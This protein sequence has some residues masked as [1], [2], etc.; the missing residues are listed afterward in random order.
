MAMVAVSGARHAGERRAASGRNRQ[1][2]LSVRTHFHEAER[3]NGVTRWV[4]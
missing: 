2:G 3:L 4:T 1:E